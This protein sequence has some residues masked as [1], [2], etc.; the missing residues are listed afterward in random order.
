MGRLLIV[1]D[2]P[3]TLSGLLELLSDEGY[4]VHGATHGKQALKLAA[5]EPVDVV[6]C[7]YSLPDIN[8]I[9]V[10]RELKRLHPRLIL[11]LITAFYSSKIFNAAREC[12]IKKVFTKPMVLDDLFETLLIHSKQNKFNEH[13][14]NSVLAIA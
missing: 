7:D 13:Y 4:Q 1:E 5:T 11:V 8:G 14:T 3:N 12:G 9:E 10:C 2:D 6:L